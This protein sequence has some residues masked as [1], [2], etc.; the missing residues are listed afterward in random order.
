MSTEPDRPL[1]IAVLASRSGTTLQALIDAC[2]QRE[3]SARIVL[4]ISNNS[5]S[6]AMARASRH[7][8]PAAHLSSRTHA[9]PVAL[10]RAIAGCLGQQAPDLVVL[11]GY[12]KKLGAHTLG[13]YR[14]RV[15]NTHP[16]LLPRHGGEG[17]YGERVHAAVIAGGDALTGVSIHLVD[18]GYDTGAVLAQREV[19]VEPGDDAARLAARVQAVEKPLLIAVLNRIARGEIA[20]PASGRL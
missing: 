5:A 13:A 1:R 4:V 18:A 6:G 9:D 10:D 3:L 7:G 8:I 15:I 12:M 20:L 14:G 19:P 16:A 11:A 17:M 2:E